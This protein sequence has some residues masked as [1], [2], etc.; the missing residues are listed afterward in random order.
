MIIAQYGL[1]GILMKELVLTSPAFQNNHKIPEKYTCNGP[2]PPLIIEGIPEAAKSLALILDDPDA[3]GGTFDHWI[4]WN[5][6]SLQNSIA[7]NT[8]PGVEG[9]NSDHEHGYIGPCPPQGKA[10]R[11]IF[12]VYAV[13]KMLTLSSKSGKRELQKALKDHVLT[14][15]KLIGLFE[16]FR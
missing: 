9:L 14:E 10:H 1:E 8:S 2:N 3:P 15:G 7:E 11:Y 16:R 5:I 13:D 4:V 12:R 6:P